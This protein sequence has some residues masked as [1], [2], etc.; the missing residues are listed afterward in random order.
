[1]T[2]GD[3]ETETDWNDLRTATGWA[4]SD[5]REGVLELPRRIAINLVRKELGEPGTVVDVGGGPGSF[6]STFLT[7]F[8][9][10][11]GIWCDISEPMMALARER[12]APYDDRVSFTLAGFEDTSKLPKG[13]DVIITSRALHH[14]PVEQVFR[15][16]A[17]A[18][19]RLTPTGWLINLD[20]VGLAEP[21][22]DRLLDSYMDMVPAARTQPTHEHKYRFATVSE[23]FNALRAAGL[24]DADMPWRA[25]GMCL[26]MARRPSNGGGEIP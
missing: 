13:L 26:F 10:T 4:R 15:F 12:L 2:R 16:Y 9:T 20:H 21:W 17:D 1:M 5:T 18:A 19:D 7:R 25:F 8:E 11:R 24:G 22:G 23:H 3:N 14:L 6:L